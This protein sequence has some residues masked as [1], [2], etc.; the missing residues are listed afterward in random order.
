MVF[1]IYLIEHAMELISS[2]NNTIAIIAINHEDET[3][4]VLEIVPP[5]WPD[6]FNFAL[7]SANQKICKIKNT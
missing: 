7:Y 1:A 6:L 4:G 5:Q 2:F 3:L